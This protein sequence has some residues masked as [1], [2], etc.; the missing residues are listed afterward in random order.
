MNKFFSLIRKV[1]DTFEFCRKS[2]G[3]K[4]VWV[5]TC[6]FV[7]KSQTSEPE[8]SLSE[9]SGWNRSRLFE[10]SQD[11]ETSSR[12]TLVL[13]NSKFNLL[14]FAKQ[15]LKDKVKIIALGF[16]WIV[17]VCFLPTPFSVDHRNNNFKFMFR[18]NEG[19]HKNI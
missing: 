12:E 17:P 14:P 5:G 7:R 8:T 4:W 3:V 10:I 2:F 9:T 13:D 1:E 11:D 18:E 6:V 19:E 16:S 15:D